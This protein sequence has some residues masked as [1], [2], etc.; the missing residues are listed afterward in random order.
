VTESLF[1]AQATGVVACFDRTRVSPPRDFVEVSCTGR[2][3][4]TTQNGDRCVCDLA[5]RRDTETAKYAR[6]HLADSPQILDGPWVKKTDRVRHDELAVRLARARSDLRDQL[7][8]TGA[9]R[10]D[11]VE[12]LS[13]ARA[14]EPRQLET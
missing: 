1:S 5:D 10:A 4:R 13:N 2:P 7:R 14:Y 9:D 6:R 8:G 11:Q 12:L 3:E